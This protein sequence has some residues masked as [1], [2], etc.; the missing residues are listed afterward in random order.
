M[1]L[2]LYTSPADERTEAAKIMQRQGADFWK[3]YS[4]QDIEA[5][6][7]QI[8]DPGIDRGKLGAMLRAAWIE[9][10]AAKDREAFLRRSGALYYAVLDR[11]DCTKDNGDIRAE[12]RQRPELFLLA[13]IATAIHETRR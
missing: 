1:M 8:S 7:S 6:L 3:I 2:S 4:A 11:L 13:A 10:E 9:Y 5:K 12:F